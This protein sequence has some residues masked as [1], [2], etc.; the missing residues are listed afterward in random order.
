MK[1]NKTYN[2]E[3]SLVVTHPT[4][5]STLCSLSM[6]ERTGSRTF[7]KI[8]PY[9]MVLAV[10][11]P[12]YLQCSASYRD[13]PTCV[14]ELP[15]YLRVGPVVFYRFGGCSDNVPVMPELYY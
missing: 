14:K 3:D 9:V 10:Y 12:L 7:Y 15:G 5:N 11:W 8:W 13:A 2:I 6:G 1:K 4:T